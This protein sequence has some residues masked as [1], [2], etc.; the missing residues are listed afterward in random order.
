M[1]RP[2]WKRTLGVVVAA[3]ALVGVQSTSA[4]AAATHTTSCTTTED[5]GAYGQVEFAWN[6]SKTKI[7]SLTLYAEDDGRDGR[8]PAVRL[9]TET[10]DYKDHNW[11]W[12]RV[13]GGIG[14]WDSWK[15][16]A[17]DANGIR[18]ARVEVGNFKGS[19]LVYRC[20]SQSV[21]NPSY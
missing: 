21:F 18:T 2:S 20:W 14:N 17:S 8:D 9:V 11:S 19:T 6:G 12:H 13:S 7:N 3:A 5:D 1:L 4:S 10:T 15:T 16:S